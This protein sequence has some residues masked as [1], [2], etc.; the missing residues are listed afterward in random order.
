MI[1]TP[2]GFLINL[3]TLGIARA[4][5]IAAAN[6]VFGAGAGFWFAW[7][8]Q[9]FANWGLAGRF[10]AALQAAGSTHRVSPFWCFLLT[11]WPFIGAKARFKK[12]TERLN[13]VWRAAGRP[14]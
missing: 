5:W 8:L 4:R 11:G 14:A 6:K 12:A 7:L 3:F 13:D 1:P 2:P 10:N 9:P